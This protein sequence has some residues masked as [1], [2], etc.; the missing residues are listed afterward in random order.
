MG[1]S[2]VDIYCFSA[3]IPIAIGR[4]SP[5]IILVGINLIVMAHF[6]RLVIAGI[7]TFDLI[8]IGHE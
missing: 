6:I 7:N 4:N 1:V 8:F 2:S 5:I 3:V